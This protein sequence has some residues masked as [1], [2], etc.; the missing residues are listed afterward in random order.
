M[1]E[2]M[3]VKLPGCAT[4]WAFYTFI[5]GW[6]CFMYSSASTEVAVAAFAYDIGQALSA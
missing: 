6:A 1:A 5:G 2:T 4:R 3:V